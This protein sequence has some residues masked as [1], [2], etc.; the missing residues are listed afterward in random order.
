MHKD[1]IDSYQLKK[2]KEF[3]QDL[4]SVLDIDMVIINITKLANLFFPVQIA[5][6]EE[7]QKNC[8]NCTSTS[9]NSGYQSSHK[10]V[11]SSYVIC[12]LFNR[13]VMGRC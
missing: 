7:Y 8:V 12:G 3:V 1:I 11:N 13:R 2:R 9:H 5:V 10:K 6:G 4:P